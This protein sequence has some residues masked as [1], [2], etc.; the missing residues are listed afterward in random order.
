MPRLQAK[1]NGELRQVDSS[2]ERRALSTASFLWREEAD[3][4]LEATDRPRPERD[5]TFG[6]S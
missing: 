5:P 6:M 3:N 2:P 1:Q 4:F